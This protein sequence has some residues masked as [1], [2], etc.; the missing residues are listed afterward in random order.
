MTQQE[1][2][3]ID[4][5]KVDPIRPP[6]FYN[7]IAIERGAPD[8]WSWFEVNVIGVDHT[9]PREAQYKHGAVMVKGAVCTAVYKSGP[10]KGLKNWSKRT[11]NRELVITFRE[12]DEFKAK[13]E[14]ATGLCSR[15][16]HG[17]DAGMELAGST[18]SGST[19]RPC[20]RHRKLAVAPMGVMIHGVNK[21][22]T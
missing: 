5:L 2:I 17:G 20:T 4:A 14:A 21:E 1:L 11:D 15:C 13:W 16:G 7:L 18:S 22:A 8:G 10:R 19:F 9:A 6:D 12:V 3:A